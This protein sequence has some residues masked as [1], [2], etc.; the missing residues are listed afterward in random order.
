M[1]HQLSFYHK[2]LENRLLWE[3]LPKPMN[4]VGRFNKYHLFAFNWEYILASCAETCDLFCIVAK[5]GLVDKSSFLEFRFCW[6]KYSSCYFLDLWY[7]WCTQW[8]NRIWSFWVCTI[9][10]SGRSAE[11]WFLI[12]QSGRSQVCTIPK[13]MCKNLEM[14]GCDIVYTYRSTTRTWQTLGHSNAAEPRGLGQQFAC[15]VGLLMVDIITPSFAICTMV[16]WFRKEKGGPC[17]ARWSYFTI[18]NLCLFGGDSN[19]YHISSGEYH[20]SPMFD[21][22]NVLHFSS[23]EV[24]GRMPMTPECTF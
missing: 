19:T 1:D 8:F 9:P 10:K 4:L 6:M 17:L 21:W 12:P 23:A 13:S 3:L 14:V 22:Q 16:P 18:L 5:F 2:Q 20:E 15:T 24:F 11:L 7:L